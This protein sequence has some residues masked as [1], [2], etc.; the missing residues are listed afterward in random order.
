MSIRDVEGRIS[1]AIVKVI[2]SII[3]FTAKNY[4]IIP[5]VVFKVIAGLLIKKF[6]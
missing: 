1:G 3:Q 5:S 2:S 4:Q 6:L